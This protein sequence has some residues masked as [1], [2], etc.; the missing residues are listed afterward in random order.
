MLTIHSHTPL[1]KIFVDAAGFQLPYL[2]GSGL[3]GES[4]AWQL[5][6]KWDG[7]GTLPLRVW[8]ESPL[9]E[10]I[11]LFR[12]GNVPCELPAY[13]ERQDSDYLSV[14]PG[15]FP[16]PLFPLGEHLDVS[17]FAQTVVWAEVQI[18]A[19]CPPGE[20]PVTFRAEGRGEEAESTFTLTVAGAAL[21]EQKLRYT[22]WLHGDC[23]A[24]WYGVPVYGDSY[25]KLLKSYLGE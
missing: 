20:Y 9:L 19:D 3:Q 8:V 6:V 14:K 25:W 16:D 24:E 13:P 17:G 2:R 12:V 4:V 21:P 22:Q 1:D 18:P 10:H 15:I 7:W 23:L 11:R 5:A